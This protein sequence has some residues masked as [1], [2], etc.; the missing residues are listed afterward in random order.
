MST[1]D[2]DA[3]ASEAKTA[4][5]TGAT[6][7]IGRRLVPYLRARGWR[8]VAL[9]RSVEAAKR[10]LEADGWVECDLCGPEP[11][12]I[13]RGVDTVFHLAGK[14]HAILEV[15][16]EEAAYRRLNTEATARLLE[17]AGRAGVRA[18]VYFS[19]V[20]AVADPRGLAGPADES[21]TREP[22]TAYGR[23][24]LEAERIV[25]ADAGVPHRVVLRPT[26]V[27]GPNPKGNLRKMADAVR[28][29]RFPPLPETG[30]RRS[31]VHVDDV[32]RAALACAVC[33]AANGRVYIVAD[34]RPFSTRMLFEWMS[35]AVGRPVPGWTLPL[36]V[37]RLLGRAGDVIGRVRGR[38]FVFD[39]QAL[40][41]LTESAW[42]SAERLKRDVGWQPSR[43]LRDS[44]RD[45]VRE[46]A[47]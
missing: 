36:W 29:G 41:R 34:D 23:S 1:S 2:P 46:E 13:P 25:L 5:V 27:Y 30:N 10:Q 17:A 11:V 14:A 40:D 39:S 22:G 15:G 3:S 16:E 7:F 31:A 4:L 37:L 6:G 43:T 45:M 42:Y 47:G 44:L 33:E 20:K 28:R 26:L 38:R 8:V 9:V 12:G 18:F 19:S 21:W 32:C 24:K 35:E